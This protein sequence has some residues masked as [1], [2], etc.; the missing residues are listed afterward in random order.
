MALSHHDEFVSL[1]LAGG[2]DGPVQARS[3]VRLRISDDRILVN[4]VVPF[5]SCLGS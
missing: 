3:R 1:R 5:L 2:G 4:M